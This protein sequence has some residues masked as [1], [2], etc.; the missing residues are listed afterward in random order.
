M[1]FNL[2]SN[3]CP[4]INDVRID[5]MRRRILFLYNGDRL[6]LDR[7]LHVVR[8]LGLENGLCSIPCVR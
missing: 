1:K 2:S 3:S 5:A 6:A 4:G 8:S 7:S